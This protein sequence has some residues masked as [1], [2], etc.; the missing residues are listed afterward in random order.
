MTS[1]NAL[2]VMDIREAEIPGNC[3]SQGRK[4]KWKECE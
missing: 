1:L 2:N 4:Y 3:N